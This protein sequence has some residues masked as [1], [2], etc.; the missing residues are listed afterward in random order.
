MDDVDVL[1]RAE[2]YARMAR[3]ASDPRALLARVVEHFGLAMPIDRSPIALA[4]ALAK[5]DL[6][7][8]EAFKA[9]REALGRAGKSYVLNRPAS[10]ASP[11]PSGEAIELQRWIA[12]HRADAV[13]ISHG[14]AWFHLATRE[15]RIARRGDDIDTHERAPRTFL[16]DYPLRAPLVF[17]DTCS[18][19]LSELCDRIAD[20]YEDI[21]R[22][23]D[24]YGVHSHDRSDLVIEEL[25]WFPE[26]ELVYPAM[27]S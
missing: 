8:G 27:G 14:D 5:A 22:A 1:S 4:L 23:P 6:A 17:R 26:R 11:A 20:A 10:G 7:D 12:A 21:Y 15:I 25:L 16:L 24:T 3:R 18:L 2:T 9:L 13:A 19:A